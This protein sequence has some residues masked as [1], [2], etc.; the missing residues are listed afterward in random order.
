[1]NRQEELM[2][3]Q[4]KKNCLTMEGKLLD[5]AHFRDSLAVHVEADDELQFDE[6]LRKCDVSKMFFLTKR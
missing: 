4:Q 2:H 3:V 5:A 6:I 1:M